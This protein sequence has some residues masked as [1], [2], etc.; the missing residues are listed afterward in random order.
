MT[1][2]F[3][4]RPAGRHAIE[5]TA[6]RTWDFAPNDWTASAA[7]PADLDYWFQ[8]G[9]GELAACRLLGASGISAKY[10]ACAFLD[11]DLR[12]SSAAVDRLFAVGEFFRLNL[13]QPALAAE[14]YICWPHVARQA[15]SYVRR[16]RFVEIMAPSSRPPP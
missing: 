10:R 16:T 11:D 8:R 4:A 9:R 15:N 5:L 3:I 13:W 12:V 6:H 14:S 7:P 1:I 2:W